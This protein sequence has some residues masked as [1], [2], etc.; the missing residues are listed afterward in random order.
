MLFEVRNA[1]PN[2]EAFRELLIGLSGAIL[3][4]RPR[5]GRK[6]ASDP[7]LSIVFPDLQARIS[8]GKANREPCPED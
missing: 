1:F 8:E 3:L 7:Q 5:A 6:T 4:R 2:H